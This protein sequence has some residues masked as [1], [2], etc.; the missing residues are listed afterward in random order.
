MAGPVPCSQRGSLAVQAGSGGRSTVIA[1]Q[2]SASLRDN[3]VSVLSSRAM[4]AM[5]PLQATLADGI[6]ATGC[7]RCC[8][9]TSEMARP[10]GDSHLPRYIMAL[11]SI[12]QCARRK[13]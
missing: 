6:T 12:L 5:E 10:F 9:F 2:G 4:D 7:A 11:M 3:I 13:V 1:T 8:S